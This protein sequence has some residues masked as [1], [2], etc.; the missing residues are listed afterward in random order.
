MQFMHALLPMV[1]AMTIHLL[2]GAV[3]HAQPLEP[4]NACA[5][6]KTEASGEYMGA[7]IECHPRA[8]VG[9][10]EA[11]D[12]CVMRAAHQLT[13]RFAAIELQGGCETI[14]D[15]SAVIGRVDASVVDIVA[16]LDLSNR[17]PCLRRQLFAMGRDAERQ[18]ECVADAVSQGAG[19][20]VD[21]AC[22]ARVSD[23][24]F[25]Q[26]ERASDRGCTGDAEAIDAAIRTAAA[27]ARN[28]IKVPITTC[29]PVEIAAF[30]GANFIGNSR[31]A[32]IENGRVGCMNVDDGTIASCAFVT[33]A[34]SQSGEWLESPQGEFA[35]VGQAIALDGRAGGEY[36]IAARVSDAAPA[37]C[38]EPAGLDT[39][40]RVAEGFELVVTCVVESLGEEWNN[41]ISV[42]GWAPLYNYADLE[43]CSSNDPASNRH[44][45]EAT[46]TRSYSSSGTGPHD[47]FCYSGY[48]AA[49]NDLNGV[50]RDFFG[51][52]WLGEE[53]CHFIQTAGLQVPGAKRPATFSLPAP[54]R[55]NTKSPI[56]WRPVNPN[57]AI[58]N[59]G[60]TPPVQ[61]F[62][63]REA[64]TAMTNARIATGAIPDLGEVGTAVTTI[65]SIA[66]SLALGGN[67]L[68]VG[69][70][71]TGAGPDWYPDLPGNDIALGYESLQLQVASPVN[72]VGFEFVEPNVTMPP[73]G[74]I[75]VDSTFEIVLYRGSAEVGRTTFNAADDQV[76]FV[77]VWSTRA[78]DRVTII[79]QTG[80]N[81]D[82]YFG[83]F[84]V[85]TLPK[86]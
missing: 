26:F 55:I 65:G 15:A 19:H 4:I 51:E 31:L 42:Y 59:G 7:V 70:S 38:V 35:L 2:W 28:T 69:T 60:G 82:E 53:F 67:E 73:Y 3:A 78:F 29:A 79:D 37:A 84:Y 50:E 41:L 33:T 11:Y 45:D 75:P 85:G 18:T 27:L 61:M 14:D 81:D 9:R 23:R 36:V 34:G 74:G 12:R 48:G 71:G 13:L 30:H 1:A 24:F 63:R 54:G 44:P 16:L 56:V 21:L 43:V 86:P 76:G 66:F 17:N 57:V 40:G 72:A 49:L 46:L 5:A 62:D 47:T 77:G 52:Y 6:K 32:E 83:R 39:S 20:S 64:F 22:Q 8:L 80:N 25:E 68:A 10:D 58:A